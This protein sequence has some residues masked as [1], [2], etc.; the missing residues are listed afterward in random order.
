MLYKRQGNYWQKLRKRLHVLNVLQLLAPAITAAQGNAAAEIEAVYLRALELC[1]QL[2][3]KTEQFPVL[4]GLRS[5]YLITG[6]LD[7]AHRLAGSLLDL[8]ESL[9]NRGLIL[10]AHVGLA[11]CYFY[12]GNLKASYDHAV[13]GIKIYDRSIY[14]DHAAKYGLD[15]GVFCYARA[16]Q[17]AW[18]LGQPERGLE[19]LLHGTAIAETANHPYS[20]VFAIH[21]LTLIYLYRREGEA[22]LKSAG[23]GSKLALHHGFNFMSAWSYYL[24]LSSSIKPL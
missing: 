23:Q 9:K 13:K 20:H 3:D 10:E 18:A 1:Q 17:T 7:Q 21:N 4:F 11:S 14:A 15:P 19:Y 12:L 24:I 22:A 2:D 8:A 5:F 16:G 6:D